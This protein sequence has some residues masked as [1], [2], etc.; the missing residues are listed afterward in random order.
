MSDETTRNKSKSKRRGG[1][2]RAIAT[3]VPKLTKKALGKRRDIG[4]TIY[5][6][7]VIGTDGNDR[8]LLQHDL[9]EPDV[10]GLGWR[11][12]GAAPRQ[13]APLAV[14]PGKQ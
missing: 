14:V 4:P 3:L 12:G 11:A 7:L 10:V 5:E 6:T 1:G 8:R 2:P 9:A 13:I